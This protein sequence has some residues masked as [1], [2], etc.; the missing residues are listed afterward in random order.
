MVSLSP[1]TVFPASF[2]RWIS[3]DYLESPGWAIVWQRLLIHK[4]RANSEAL[5]AN[6]D[7]TSRPTLSKSTYA[8]MRGV[9]TV[10]ESELNRWRRTF[11]T[12]AKS[13][14]DSGE[15][16]LV[17]CNTGVLVNMT[18]KILG[19]RKLRE[20]NCTSSRFNTNRSRTIWHPFPGSKYIEDWFGFM[21]RV[22]CVWDPSHETG[23]GLFNGI[24]ILWSARISSDESSSLRLILFIGTKPELSLSKRSRAFLNPIPANPYRSILMGNNFFVI[25][26]ILSPYER[27]SDWIKLYL[28]KKNGVHVLGC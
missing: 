17:N 7:S 9:A 15:K 5:A 3:F 22:Y 1:V 4:T 16:C 18:F 28:G 6:S 20:C 27:A 19:Y 26:D 25:S 24:P 12:H 2:F 8:S 11:D 10:P 23:C 21:G 13:F 14:G